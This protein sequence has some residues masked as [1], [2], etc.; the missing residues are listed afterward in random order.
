MQRDKQQ[1]DRRQVLVTYASAHGS[2]AGVAA[3]VAGT[4]RAAGAK[5]D[6]HP[7]GD[8][9]DPGGY[10]AVVIG[11]PIRYDRWLPAA[12]TYLRSHEAALSA[13]PVACF[14]T[15]MALSGPGG[16]AQAAGYAR[17]LARQAATVR[18]VS[19]GRFAGALDYRNVLPPLRWP[20]RLLFSA[21]G[22]HS[23]DH[24]DFDAI[25]DWSRRCL[26]PPQPRHH[27]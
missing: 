12:T 14:F 20:A 13:R 16:A 21:L 10:D 5:V 23:G 22:A 18:P 1:G 3:A 27:A 4:L 11:S 8:A 26:D 2:T 17:T 15:C 7:V 24:R 25:R 19:I 6:L 9:P